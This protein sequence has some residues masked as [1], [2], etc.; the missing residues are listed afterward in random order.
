MRKTTLLP[1]CHMAHQGAKKTAV[2]YAHVKAVGTDEMYI[3]RRDHYE[4]QVSLRCERETDLNNL[5]KNEYRIARETLD[6]AG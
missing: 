3:V 4:K 5:S 6:K 2:L 1:H